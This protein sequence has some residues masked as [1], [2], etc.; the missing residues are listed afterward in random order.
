MVG[1]QQHEAANEVKHFFEAVGWMAQICLFLMLGLLVTPRDLL[2]LIFHS[3]I[4]ALVLIFLARPLSVASC[5]APFGWR[6]REAAFVAWAGLRGGVPIFLAIIPVL[7]NK[8]GGERL[9]NAVFVTVIASVAIQ[10][11]ALAW[12]ARLLKIKS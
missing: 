8:G 6:W 5:M 7:A 12:V 3:L 2:P 4:T 9:F 11:K 10:G 1:V